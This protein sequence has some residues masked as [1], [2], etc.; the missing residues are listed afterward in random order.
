MPDEQRDGLCWCTK[1]WM[2]LNSADNGKQ[3]MT[4]IHVMFEMIRHCI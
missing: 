4:L 1:N 3:I 2:L